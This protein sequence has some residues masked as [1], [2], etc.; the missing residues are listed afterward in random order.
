MRARGAALAIIL[1]VAVVALVALPGS[2]QAHNTGQGVDVGYANVSATVANGVATVDVLLTQ[3]TT[4]NCRKLKP[5]SLTAQRA[6]VTAQGNFSTLGDCHYQG[7]L[8]PP[9]AGRWVVT[10]DFRLNGQPTSITVLI[11]V[12]GDVTSFQ[13]ADWLH[14]NSLGGGGRSIPVGALLAGAGGLLALA[15]AAR[16]AIGRRAPRRAPRR[17]RATPQPDVT[18]ST[19]PLTSAAHQEGGSA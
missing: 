12:G 9:S 19:E 13:S 6:D 16:V 11:G 7:T 2:A 3:A 1:M 8:T 10:A 17:T 15:L 18:S 5:A 4:A 14:V